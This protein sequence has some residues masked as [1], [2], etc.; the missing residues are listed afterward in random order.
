MNAAYLE[1]DVRLDA[2]TRQLHAAFLVRNDSAG[3]WRPSEGFGVG[4]HLFDAETGTLI[5]DGAR[6][7]PER[8]VKPGETARVR[9]VAG[10]SLRIRKAACSV[11]VPAS[12]LTSG[13][14]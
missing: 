11:R 14:R 10:E 6:V 2:G 3:T 13:S 8:E 9:H 4:Y 12:S 1:P 5:V 7:A